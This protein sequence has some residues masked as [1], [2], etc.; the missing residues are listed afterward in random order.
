MRGWLR[1]QRAGARLSGGWLPAPEATHAPPS[2]HLSA[3]VG[4]G[5]CVVPGQAALRYS[6][7]S[8]LHR[9]D[10]ATLW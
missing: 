2:S 7:M 1:R 9:A 8:P 3:P 4:A 5:N 6:L 10:L